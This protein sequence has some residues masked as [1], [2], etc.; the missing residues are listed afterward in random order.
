[1]LLV[2]KKK[3]IIRKLSRQVS[4][5]I[6]DLLRTN[7]ANIHSNDDWSN[8]F[9]ILQVY[10]AGANAPDILI[11][12]KHD[13]D[14]GALSRSFSFTAKPNSPSRISSD[15]NTIITIYPFV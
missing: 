12:N 1:M 15:S 8:I 10:G 2:F 7:A 3:S 6:H 13:L 4:Y 9:T 14:S 11:A 5:G